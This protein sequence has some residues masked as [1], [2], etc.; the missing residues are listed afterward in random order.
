MFLFSP[1]FVEK[2]HGRIVNVHPSLL[3]KYPGVHSLQEALDAGDSQTGMTI[4]VIDDG[5][6]TGNILLQKT[7]PILPGDTLETLKA[8]EQE[9]EKE[10]YPRVLEMIEKGE[11]KL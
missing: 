9:L 11:M 10:W 4:H 7:C 2:F 6:D 8:R 5:V 3:P 1:W